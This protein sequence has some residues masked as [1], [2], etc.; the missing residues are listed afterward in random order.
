MYNKKVM[1]DEIL[2]P[3]WNCIKVM[4]MSLVSIL[5]NPVSGKEKTRKKKSVPF[6][7]LIT[8]ESCKHKRLLPVIRVLSWYYCHNNYIIQIF[9]RENSFKTRHLLRNFLHRHMIRNLNGQD[10]D[11]TVELAQWAV[12]VKGRSN[13]LCNG[14]A[15]GVGLFS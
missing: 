10:A 3:D 4:A 9:N 8:W 14:T 1:S 13:F 6:L 5:G 12:M 11:L 2:S 7:F 15:E